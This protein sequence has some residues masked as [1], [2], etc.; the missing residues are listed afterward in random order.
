M[1]KMKRNLFI[2]VMILLTVTLS[3]FGM[4]STAA[5][6]DAGIESLRKT[7]QAFRS[8]A[9]QVSPAVVFIQVEKEVEQQ[10]YS[11]NPFGNSPF[12]DEFFRRFFG[13]PPQQE[14]PHKTP[15]KRRA[16]GQG[17]GFIISADG[18][19]MTNNHVVGDADKV[20]VQLLD[21][22]EFDAEIVGTDPPTDVALI[23]IKADEKFPFLTL[24]NS[25][26]LEVGDWVLAFGNPFGLSHTLTAG[27]VSAKGR[28]GIGLNDYE[29]FIQ[30]DAAINPGNSGGPLVNLDGEV[31]GMNTA[32]FSRSGGYMGI[33]F[34]IPINMAQG[35]RK[36]LVQHG[37]VTRGRLGVLIQDMDKNLAESFGIDQR[38]GILVAQVMEDSPADK[39]GLKQGDVIL[40]LDG[41]KVEKVATFR[42]KIALT[43]PG[44]K[45]S[46][47]ILRD[48]KKDT[49]EVEIGAMETDAKG[50]PVT[51]DSLPELG[52]KLQKLT[53]DLAEQFGYEGA[54]GVLVTAVEPGS[55]AAR[56]G[57]KRG[58][59]IEEVDRQEVKNSAE[60]KKLIKESKKKTV[61]LL[62]RQGEGSRY[63]ALKLEK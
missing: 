57:I 40:E 58:D 50:Q 9:K 53:A 4:I 33:G 36:Q 29:N 32:I 1:M 3:G 7:G 5:A 61:L 34:A 37:S 6:K 49:L 19:I 48:G 16:S 51:S 11:N 18:Y 28:S 52:M 44:T 54:S 22:R 2:P 42:N 46:L 47:Q 60:V 21:G 25:D 63:L 45:V 15:P 8:V 23:K 31:V 30:T 35:I 62:V 17:S 27:I 26:Q 38:E 20:T 39:G 12:G 55:I 13:Q 41:T 10:G 59:L 24:G 43:A 14:N 56:A